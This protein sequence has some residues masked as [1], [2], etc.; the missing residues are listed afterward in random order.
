MTLIGIRYRKFLLCLRRRVATTSFLIATL[1]A[2]IVLPGRALA[3]EP[4]S[5]KWEPA[6]LVNGSPV[7]FR[8]SPPVELA[9]LDG[10]WLGHK[11][12]FRFGQ[13]CNCWYVLAGVDLNTKVGKY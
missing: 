7:L 13:T 8:I 10:T 12:S 3:G 2:V 11:L 4:W 1:L 5:V 6:Q 9:S